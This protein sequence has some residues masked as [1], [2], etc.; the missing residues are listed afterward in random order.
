MEITDLWTIKI[1]SEKYGEL[2]FSRISDN[3]SDIISTVKSN[4]DNCI[5]KSQ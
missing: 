3:L 4:P 2:Y 1:N 5:E